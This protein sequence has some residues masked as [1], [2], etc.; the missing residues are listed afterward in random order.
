MGT[1]VLCFVETFVKPSWNLHGKLHGSLHGT[2]MTTFIATCMDPS[3][4]PPWGLH[5]NRA[6]TFVGPSCKPSR[7]FCESLHESSLDLD[8]TGPCWGSSWK[9]HGNLDGSC[10]E[11][12]WKPSWHLH[13]NREGASMHGGPMKVP[14]KVPRR[15]PW[16]SHPGFH[17]H[18]KKVAAS[19]P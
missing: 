18:S 9:L 2:F 15:F 1:S 13:W 14:M 10:V 16:G 11:P 12:S 6:G 4:E 7:I 19:I 17:V 5:G 3:R 8:F